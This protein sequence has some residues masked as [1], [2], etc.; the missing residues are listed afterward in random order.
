[1]MLILGVLG[2]YC[3]SCKDKLEEEAMHGQ[4]G[5]IFNCWKFSFIQKQSF[6]SCN[7]ETV[8]SN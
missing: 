5:S 1:M 2:I 8:W 3:F 7:K 4:K 6:L